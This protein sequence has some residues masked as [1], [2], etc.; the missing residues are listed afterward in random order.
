MSHFGM[1]MPGGKA[2]RSAAPDVYTA[3]MV[4]ATIALAAACAVVG[5]AGSKVGKDGNVFEVQQQGHVQ[6]PQK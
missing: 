5:L 1:Q 6:L 3:M 4:V 2:S